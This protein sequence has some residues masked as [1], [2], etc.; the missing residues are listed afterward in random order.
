M[1]CLRGTMLALFLVLSSISPTVSAA[2][3][4][5]IEPYAFDVVTGV[6]EVPVWV[7]AYE[8]PAGYTVDSWSFNIKVQYRIRYNTNTGEITSVEELGHEMQ[9]GAFS[10]DSRGRVSGLNYERC[11]LSI[12]NNNLSIKCT[13]SASVSLIYTEFPGVPV[14]QE[15]VTKILT[16]TATISP[17][18]DSDNL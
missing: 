10:P 9:G 11:N 18:R 17:E 1:K 12:V 6:M 3:A 16:G 7:P 15:L 8:S 5:D 13:Y 2:A 14:S 4:N